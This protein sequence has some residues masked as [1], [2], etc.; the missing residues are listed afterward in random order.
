MSALPTLI[1]STVEAGPATG[2]LS[3]RYFALLLSMA[4]TGELPTEGP[5]DDW[6]LPWRWTDP[7]STSPVRWIGGGL[8]VY[9]QAGQPVG[10]ELANARR[11][12]PLTTQP[13]I[14]QSWV[15]TPVRQHY[16]LGLPGSVAPKRAMFLHEALG[17]LHRLPGDAAFVLNLI[18]YFKVTQGTPEAITAIPELQGLVPQRVAGTDGPLRFRYE[19]PATAEARALALT[20]ALSV[21][22]VRPAPRWCRL[23]GAH[24]GRGYG[25]VSDPGTAAERD[26][27]RIRFDDPADGAA[28]WADSAGLAIFLQRKIAG[29]ATPEPWSCLTAG[30]VRPLTELGVPSGTAVHDAPAMLPIPLDVRSVMQVKEGAEELEDQEHTFEDYEEDPLF[31]TPLVTRGV[32]EEVTA[33]TE[34]LPP[35]E[36]TRKLSARDGEEARYQIARVTETAHDRFRV[37]MTC[38]GDEYRAIAIPVGLAGDAALVSSGAPWVLKEGPFDL[39][40][41]AP[42]WTF[43]RTIG[44][45]QLTMVP[46]RDGSALPREAWPS[47][48]AEVRPL[49]AELPVMRDLEPDGDTPPTQQNARSVLILDEAG[50]RPGTRQAFEIAIR[51]P[52]TPIDVVKRWCRTFDE[53]RQAFLDHFQ[54]QREGTWLDDPASD[55]FLVR[56][57]QWDGAAWTTLGQLQVRPQRARGRSA[58]SA[59]KLAVAGTPGAGGKGAGPHPGLI[60]MPAPKDGVA[61]ICR[62]EI[63]VTVPAE[64]ERRFAKGV[65]SLSTIG[66]IRA[67]PPERFL[68]EVAPRTLPAPIEL[69]RSLQVRVV[70]R[71]ARVELKPDAPRAMSQFERVDLERITWRFQGVPVAWPSGPVTADWPP[72]APTGLV[73]RAVA[74]FEYGAYD[75][76]KQRRAGGAFSGLGALDLV[77]VDRRPLDVRALLANELVEVGQDVHTGDATGRYIRYRVVARSRYEGVYRGTRHS[78]SVITTDAFPVAPGGVVGDVVHD[79]WLR[80]LVRYAG[81]RPTTPTVRAVIPLTAP[82][83]ASTAEDLQPSHAASGLLLVL[84]EAPFGPGVAERL[85]ADVLNDE[86]GPDPT[87][88]DRARAWT[89]APTLHGPFGHTN[90]TDARN[91][92]YFA[93]SYLIAPPDDA[94]AWDFARV[95]FR[96]S[97]RYPWEAAAPFERAS[98]WTTPQWIQ[99]LPSRTFSA[100]GMRAVRVGSDIRLDLVRSGSA[101]VEPRPHVD[102]RFRY[103]LLLTHRIWDHRRHPSEAFSAIVPLRRTQATTD[104]P[105]H[106]D[107]AASMRGAAGNVT[108]WATMAGEQADYARLVEIQLGTG[109]E[110]APD[111]WL[112]L[113]APLGP[114][115]DEAGG[116]RTNLPDAIGRA[117]RISARVSLT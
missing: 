70:D 60:V 110:P 96:R 42:F 1:V 94:R 113:L 34:P 7:E 52:A 89:L 51:G 79:G 56:L 66:G 27:I 74:E 95:R 58:W 54:A 14:L 47:I 43:K 10:H 13:E 61:C 90:D 57:L 24:T 93:G 8:R 72:T 63:H 100:T 116:D 117:V 64:A 4:W 18:S 107:L 115:E 6:M 45:G 91:P 17:S 92:G 32:D 88:D 35:I 48:P 105:S 41:E 103:L 111:A 101:V 83:D 97:V 39:P 98:D 19:V 108:A 87:L 22:R 36:G 81:P 49:S 50:L 26:P 29:S 30:W 106:A 20:E 59:F 73:D 77:R 99:V 15:K 84:D 114:A 11:S 28:D 67:L 37:P 75:K 85:D 38:Y 68:I 76:Q 104:P 86:S 71:V 53:R 69:F 102:D 21:S 44:L 23:S 25:D 40:D 109:D 62:C 80:A 65:L 16:D 46:A 82:I 2:N 12:L 55:G 31:A 33:P 112:E 78:D 9:D 3:D 5:P